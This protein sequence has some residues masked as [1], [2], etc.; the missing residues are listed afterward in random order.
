M[1]DTR[2]GGSTGLLQRLRS[3]RI[4]VADLREVAEQVLPALATPRLRLDV[5][6]RSGAGS[7][8]V[9]EEDERRVRVHLGELADAMTRA[10]VPATPAGMRRALTSWV[11]HRP[12]TDA[13]AAAHLSLIHI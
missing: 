3:T 2:F 10:G 9:L 4:G 7:V 6:A 12:V 1:S 11:A 13:A 8:V 5:V